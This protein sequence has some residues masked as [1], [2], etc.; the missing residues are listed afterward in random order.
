MSRSDSPPERVS[1]G[2]L[3]LT[4]WP[5]KQKKRIWIYLDRYFGHYVV[6]PEWLDWLTRGGGG[7]EGG[8]DEGHHISN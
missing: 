5:R 8:G 1:V 7:N 2:C 3:H 6:G 4:S